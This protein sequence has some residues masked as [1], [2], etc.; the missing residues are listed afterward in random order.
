MYSKL[1]EAR[2]GSSP[3]S[4]QKEHGSTDALI[5]ALFSDF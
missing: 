4:L 2:E 3:W 1:E 5:S